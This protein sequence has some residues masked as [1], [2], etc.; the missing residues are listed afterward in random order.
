MATEEEIKKKMLQQRMQQQQA[1]M[2]E[3]MMQ[4]Q[5]LQQAEETLKLLMSQIL[6]NKA[7][8]RLSNLKLVRPELAMQLQLYLAQLYQAGQIKQKITDDQIVM[9]LKKLTEKRDTKITRK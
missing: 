9:I 4:Q 7:R 8:E 3:A 5:Q 2:G 6:D 1:A